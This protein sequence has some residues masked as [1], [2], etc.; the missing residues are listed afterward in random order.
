MWIVVAVK[1][2]LARVVERANHLAINPPLKLLLG[3][4]DG[5]VVPGALRVVDLEVCA[6]IERGGISFAE[7][8][9]QDVRGVSAE[10]FPINFCIPLA[11]PILN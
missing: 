11:Y 5:V 3:P 2:A 4:V 10:E 7:E 9:G 6:T 1:S 8:V